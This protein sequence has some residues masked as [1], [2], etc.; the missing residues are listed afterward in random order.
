[1]DSKQLKI[2]F[3]KELEDR[4]EMSGWA[5]DEILR[6]FDA[7]VEKVETTCPLCGDGCSC[8]GGV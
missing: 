6:C 3:K 2:V 7:A 1:M 8:K 4:I 5:A